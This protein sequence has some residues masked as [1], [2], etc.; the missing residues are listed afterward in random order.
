MVV[1][2]SVFLWLIHKD[3]YKV[4]NFL[5]SIILN[6][7]F[8]TYKSSFYTIKKSKLFSQSSIIK[9]YKRFVLFK[10]S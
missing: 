4:V 8:K 2:P 7:F 9:S 10:I 1:F 3:F 6:V 5:V